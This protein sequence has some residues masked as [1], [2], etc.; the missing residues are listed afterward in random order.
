MITLKNTETG[1]VK[2]V[3]EGFSWTN[4]FFGVF[5]ALYRWD[6][7]GFLIMLICNIISG[8]FTLIVFPF[9]YNSMYVYFLKLRGY[10]VV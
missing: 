10:E 7:L 6:L 2:T 3:K 4:L 8:G 5:V 9:F 1:D